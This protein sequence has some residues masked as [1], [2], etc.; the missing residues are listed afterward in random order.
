MSSSSSVKFPLDLVVQEL[1]LNPNSYCVGTRRKAILD[2]Q[3]VEKC[4][5]ILE[6]AEATNFETRMVAEINLYWIIYESCSL[7][8]VD[9]PATQAL[10]NS[11]RQEWKYLFGIELRLISR[12][13]F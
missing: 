9:V 2:R 12:N 8:T 13:T 3:Q 10:L 7:P 5:R 6:S 1:Q 4:R 11:W